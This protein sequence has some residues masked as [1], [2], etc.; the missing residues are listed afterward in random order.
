MVESLDFCKEE[1][2]R[3]L[4]CQFDGEGFHTFKV[5]AG[6]SWQEGVQCRLVI[7]LT[8]SRSLQVKGNVTNR[9]AT[10]VFPIIT[11]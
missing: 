7:D 10:P 5:V 9:K 3:Y 2:V 6:W 1:T 11:Q 8:L 4:C